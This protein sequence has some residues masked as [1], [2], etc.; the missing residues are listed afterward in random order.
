MRRTW[1]TLGLFCLVILTFG[2]ANAVFEV[3]AI[4][5][6]ATDGAISMAD[7]DSFQ[8]DI[9]FKVPDGDPDVGGGKIAINFYSQDGS[10]G[11][12][13]HLAVPDN[14]L[15][16]GNISTHSV[17]Y[18]N[19][20]ES[21]F[22]MMIYAWENGWGDGSL[23]DSVA[24]D[25]AAL[26][27][28]LT[29]AMPD[30]AYLRFNF[31][32]DNPGIFC[33]APTIGGEGEQDWMF[34]F[35]GS[36]YTF[37]PTC[38]TIGDYVVDN[39]PVIT[40][41]GDVE[42]ECGSDYLPPTTGVAT[43]EDLVDPEDPIISYSDADPVPGTCPTIETITR[44]WTATDSKDQ[45][46]SCDQI[47]TIVDNT[48]PVLTIPNEITV[49]CDADAIDLGITGTATATDGC[50]DSPVVTY[51]DNTISDVITRTWTATDAC[52]NSA[53]DDQTITILD[54]TDP[55]VAC[56][57]DIVVDNETGTCGA[58]VSFTID[59][60]TDN[61]DASVDVV[62]DPAS[63]TI[64]DLG[65]TLVT[66]TATDD[67][68]NV[69]TCTFN[70]TV[71]DAD[72]PI[73]I[74][75]DDIALTCGD[76]DQ[77][78]FTGTATGSDLCDAEVDF[79]FVDAAPVAGVVTRT[80][81]AT[82]DGGNTATCDQLITLAVD[83][84][85]PTFVEACPVDVTVECDQVPEPATMTATDNCAGVTLTYSEVRTDGPCANV[86]V[87]VRTWTAEDNSGNTAECSQNVIVVDTSDPILT[88]CPDDIILTCGA[89]SDPSN[90]GTPV[91]T[92]NCG[93]PTYNYV[94]GEMVE[95]SFIRTWTIADACGNSVPCDQ[96]I[97][98]E[99][100][101]EV[102]QF[103]QD[104]PISV[105]VDCK[106]IPEPAVLTA[107]D[108]C[109]ASVEV[110]FS[111]EIIPGDCAYNYTIERTWMVFDAAGNSNGCGQNI[112]I[113]DN[114]A[115]TY[116]VCPDDFT[117]PYGQTEY[118]P[119]VTGQ[120]VV[121]DN[122]DSAPSLEYTDGA[123]IGNEIDGYV[124]DRHW[125]SFDVCGN[126]LDCFQ[127]IT[128]EGMGDP[129]LIADPDFFDLEVKQYDTLKNVMFDIYERYSRQVQITNVTS[130][131]PWLTIN[132][133]FPI[134][135]SNVIFFD[136][137]AEF[138]TY[139]DYTA[140]ISVIS[141][142]AQN[143]PLEIPVNL[144]V[145]PFIAPP[146][147]VWVATV[148]AVPGGKAVVSVYFKNN[149]DLS[150][151]NVPMG[152][153][154]DYMEFDS[155]SFVGT[156]VEY[157]SDFEKGYSFSNATNQ[158]Q[159]TVDPTFSPYVPGGRGLLAKLFFTVNGDVMT[160][161]F[162]ALNSTFIAPDGYVV[163]ENSDGEEDIPIYTPGGVVIDDQVA[164]VCGSV[165][166]VINDI[167]VPVEGAMVEFWDRF[168]V[169]ALQSSEMS[170]VNGQF[171]CGT[172]GIVPFDA[173]A[174]KEGYYPGMVSAIDFGTLGIEIL[175][176]KVPEVVESNVWVL[177]FSG[178]RLGSCQ[179]YFYNIPLP[180]GA[181]VDAYTN[182]SP[183]VHCGTYYVD[184]AGEYSMSVYGDNPQTA[185]KD[186]AWEGD[187]IK[188][189]INGYP[190]MTEAP[191]YW[192]ESILSM[193]ICF[194]LF[195]VETRTI[196]LHAGKNLISWNLD[197][198]DD[199]IEVIFGDVMG[200]VTAI[201]GFEQGGYTYDPM[202]PEFST[203]L[204]ADHTH[205]YWVE[206]ANPAVLTVQGSPVAPTTPITLESEWNL[207]SYLPD[208]PYAPAE[209]L[210]SVLPELEA[211]FSWDNK[212]YDAIHPE[213]ST[214][215]TMERGYGYWLYMTS[216]A[217]LIYPGVGPEIIF[218]QGP[219]K[220]NV[221]VLE[222][223][224][225]TSRFWTNVFSSNLT[226]DGI[227]VPKGAEILA[228]A[229]D[230]RV[231]GSGTI[232]ENG[233]F[234]FMPVYGDDPAT[235]DIDGL[236]NDETFSLVIDGVATDEQ[237]SRISDS[238]RMEVD[239]VTTAKSGNQLLPNQFGLAQNYPNPF[240]PSTSISFSVPFATNV[241]LEVFNILGEKVATPF[242]GM[243]TT[244]INE[245]IWDGRNESGKS[246]A[247]GI[248]FYRMQANDFEKT[249]KMVLMK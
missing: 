100:D 248:Y 43:A 122:C 30:Q 68:G 46:S 181:V 70:V 182:E 205:G 136:V 21:I 164:F 113:D 131:E 173:Y 39:P 159:I 220:F 156:R 23:P 212:T 22:N 208:M 178:E 91:A 128:L 92:D 228:V 149:D 27:G 94:D 89:S 79:S 176:T 146:D 88:S 34:P 242:S 97:T 42:V 168:P 12:I 16:F 84:E 74:C 199:D 207:V 86:Y 53:S 196:D 155:V 240:N 61:C 174:Y 96:T 36:A 227:P 1:L 236:Q 69:A 231:V 17:E 10:L 62:A 119:D 165:V 216:G 58:T 66:V 229:S 190:T 153:T 172:L 247:S 163:F 171:A 152:W 138:L 90:T 64:F 109:D 41:P 239:A 26:M 135:T 143:S 144:Y 3:K 219:A 106:A 201:L 93:D 187:E 32:A 238:H 50:D 78:D 150:R 167:K 214:L 29:S 76:S 202:Y 44:T 9:W 154:P 226:L 147:S 120:A 54:T 189:F 55:I 158:V 115:P 180:V 28:A 142:E 105:T 195:R 233:R 20:F 134:S 210:A 37:E 77:P 203:L 72:A 145:E 183:A 6:Q 2:Q 45:S 15:V 71:N 194:D 132:T 213:Y 151:I 117:V 186:G 33:V 249:Y 60:A 141:A 49:E 67:A 241:T 225:K 234:G 65:T 56:P 191:V 7:A 104:C 31:R 40:C 18:L 148:P 170:D 184:F 24:Y 52:G 162:T 38:F 232:G 116:T 5:P 111:E 82:D 137:N 237:F 204:F 235:P 197:T 161:A 185:E 139:G 101:E 140:T 81:T 85:P 75:P 102:P 188:F 245:V 166:E 63:G 95:G 246:V 51:S 47:I 215:E 200:D 4:S 48:A 110:V 124:F 118:G 211:A 206:M 160:P 80:W 157:I 127:M 209:A 98:I 221:A 14:P 114:E 35:D 223:E 19:G 126:R 198:P 177:Y 87:L 175:L 108:N 169:G 25:V 57:T 107:T 13:T 218:G 222:N 179:S 99:D 83:E 230:N 121:E 123:L 73:I 11:N 217:T 8:V 112:Y 192:S 130:S 193:E 59:P 133:S 224:I 103:D 243:A 125:V 244:G 129:F